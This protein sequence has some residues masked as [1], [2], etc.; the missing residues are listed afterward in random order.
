MQ[1][2]QIGNVA[3]LYV[4]TPKNNIRLVRR[5][6]DSQH[7][8]FGNTPY[9]FLVHLPKLLYLQGALDS[10]TFGFEFVHDIHSTRIVRLAAQEKKRGS[11]S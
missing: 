9:D 1:N 8:Y 5:S 10:F 4:V 2:L 6:S 11:L 3:F 7:I